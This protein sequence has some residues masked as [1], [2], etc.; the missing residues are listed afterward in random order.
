M[1]RLTKRQGNSVIIPIEQK[2]GQTFPV[3]N[4]YQKAIEKLAAYEDT[5]L[6]PEEIGDMKTAYDENQMPY[7]L[8][9]TGSEAVHIVDLLQAEAEGRLVVLPCK[10]GDEVYLNLDGQTHKMRVQGISVAAYSTNCIIH[11]GGYPVTNLWGDEFG[12][13]AFLTKEEAEAALEKMKG[14]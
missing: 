14:E 3:E 5:G 6:E 9:A 12:K 13:T 4:P 2:R 11:F 10:V 8:E 1:E 7:M